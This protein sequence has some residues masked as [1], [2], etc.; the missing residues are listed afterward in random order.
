MSRSYVVFSKE[1]IAI[2]AWSSSSD[3]GSSNSSWWSNSGGSLMHSLT[4]LVLL[5]HDV[6]GCIHVHGSVACRRSF[7]WAFSFHYYWPVCRHSPS[8]FHSFTFSTSTFRTVSFMAPKACMRV[9]VSLTILVQFG[10]LINIGWP[11]YILS[12]RLSRLLMGVFSLS[13]WVDMNLMSFSS[14]SVGKI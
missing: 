14:L 4:R 11:D 7:K 10:L 6:R 12:D 5:F 2:R 8:L 9:T 3:V 1:H 13:V